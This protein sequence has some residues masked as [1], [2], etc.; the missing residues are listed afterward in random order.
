MT[1]QPSRKG[2]PYKCPELRRNPGIPDSRFRAFELPSRVNSRL[3]HPDGSV[4]P[5]P[6]A[7]Q[8]TPAR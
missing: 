2:E 8:T 3:H 7:A 4:T 1:T 5:V 6:S